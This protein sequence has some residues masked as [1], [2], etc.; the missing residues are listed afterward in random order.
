M[1]HGEELSLRGYAGVVEGI[2][3]CNNPQNLEDPTMGKGCG[4]RLRTSLLD[5]PDSECHR[6]NKEEDVQGKP[7]WP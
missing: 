2:R 6:A 7:E 3:P 5:E 4:M 1:G